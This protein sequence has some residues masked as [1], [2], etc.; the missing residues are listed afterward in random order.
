MPIADAIPGR[1]RDLGGFSVARVLPYPKRRSLGPFVFFDEMGPADFPPGGGIDVRPHPHIG[2]ATITWLF[3]GALGHADSLG[4]AIDIHPG[5]V[6]WM[7]AGRGI[8]HSERTPPAQRELGHHMH[9]IQTWVALPV[10]DAE[11]DPAFDHFPADTMPRHSAD[12]VEAVV[13]AGSLWGL[14]SPV[15]FP[16]PIIY[17]EVR[18]AAG[19]RLAL[20]AEWGER[21]VYLVSGAVQVDGAAV[22][23]GTLA[24][25]DD[26]DGELL[27][28]ADSL[29]MLLGGAPYP[30]G[31][32][33]EWNFVSHDPARIAQAVADWRAGHFQ[34]VPG[35][36]E[37]IPY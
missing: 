11:C 13:I 36:P 28:T 15:S 25:L 33:I 30:E 21:G 29:L 24:V 16:H 22:E 4:T 18:L 27:A 9:G 2:L 34:M 7:T 20:P 35:D 5:A 19:A 26:G 23:T 37:F 12:G 1:T 8:V 10:A 31:R 14:T 3:A 17:A 32:H 6:N